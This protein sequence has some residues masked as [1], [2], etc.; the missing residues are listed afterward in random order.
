MNHTIDQ[1]RGLE[2]VRTQAGKTCFYS[3]VEPTDNHW[4]LGV[5][6][7]ASFGLLLGMVL[8]A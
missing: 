3:D 4:L 8:F 6:A 5:S 2:M 7:L 1:M